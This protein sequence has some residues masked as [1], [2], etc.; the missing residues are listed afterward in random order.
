MKVGIRRLSSNILYPFQENHL[1]NEQASA[2]KT[3]LR[4]WWI[5]REWVQ[6]PSILQFTLS[7][8]S[9]SLL[10]PFWLCL[11]SENICWRHSAVLTLFE[12]PLDWMDSAW[13]CRAQM[14]RAFLNS[15]HCIP[16]ES[17]GGWCLR[18]TKLG[19]RRPIQKRFHHMFVSSLSRQLNLLS[20]WLS[21]TR[22]LLLL[23]FFFYL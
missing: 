14:T 12:W 1:K 20:Y 23:L 7:R 2:I 16:A 9:V 8:L 13:Q 21:G 19:E 15:N 6:E 5:R 17:D 3:G 18:E 4:H 11:H 22:W 10:C